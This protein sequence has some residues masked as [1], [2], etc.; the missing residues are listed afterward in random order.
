ML[1]WL[2]LTPLRTLRPLSLQLPDQQLLQQGL[3]MSESD[4]IER[5]MME[6]KLE[7]TDMEATGG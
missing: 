1:H 6:D 7:S 3:D 4:D 2:P 5:V